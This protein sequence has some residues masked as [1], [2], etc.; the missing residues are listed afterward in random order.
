[1]I[2][3]FPIS[4]GWGQMRGSKYLAGGLNGCQ[5]HI[6]DRCVAVVKEPGSQAGHHPCQSSRISTYG[7][8]VR[9][10]LG[11]SESNSAKP[12][13]HGTT[14]AVD[15][16]QLRYFVPTRQEYAYYSLVHPPHPPPCTQNGP[17]IN[18]MQHK[19]RREARFF[20]SIGSVCVS[21]GAN[22]TL[23]RTDG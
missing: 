20:H 8:S 17:H 13:R 12:P 7:P 11:V 6:V 14:P 23:P 1:M 16:T 22:T 18:A 2:I 9:P 19:P 10:Q 4:W 3:M 5:P 15:C 21:L